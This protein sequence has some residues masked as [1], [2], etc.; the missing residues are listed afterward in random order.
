MYCCKEVHD[1]LVSIQ[2]HRGKGRA[3]ESVLAI[4]AYVKIYFDTTTKAKNKPT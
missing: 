3:V 2:T 1:S 4:I